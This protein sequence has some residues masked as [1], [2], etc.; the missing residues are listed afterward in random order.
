MSLLPIQKGADNPILRKKGVKIPAVTKPLKKLIKD[1]YETVKTEDGA[2]LA[3]PQVGQSLQ[4]CL[5]LMEGKM[6]VLINPEIVWKSKELK[7]EEEGCL[8]LPKLQVAVERPLS[9][10][11]KYLNEKGLP[12]ERK[13]IDFSARTVQHEVDHLNGVLLVDYLPTRLPAPSRETAA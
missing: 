5:A 8:S 4:L 7:T 12:E 2:G 9:V 6:T 1:M 10:T 3:A 13:L 11:V